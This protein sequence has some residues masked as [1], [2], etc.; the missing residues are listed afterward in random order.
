MTPLIS[1]VMTTYNR[2]AFLDCA[3]ASVLQQ[4]VS[5][6]ELLVWD[7]GSTDGSVE[8]AQAYAQQDKR[9][10][11]VAAAH[12]GRVKAL[13]AAIAQTQ[14]KYLGFV[15]SDDW[16]APTALEETVRVLE[17]QPAVGMVYTDYYETDA[18]GKVLQ[19]GQRCRIPYSPERL[20]VDFMTFHF[21]LLRRSPYD[22]VGGIKDSLDFVEDYDL[23]LRLS[24]V[25]QFERV[26]KPLYFYRIHAHNASRELQ[27]EQ[28][29][30]THWIL[31]QALRRRG[32]ADTHAID[33][34]LPA[35]RFT[36]R[37]KEAGVDS[38][39]VKPSCDFGSQYVQEAGEIQALGG[40]PP[41]PPEL[42][43]RRR[44]PNPLP[45]ELR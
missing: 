9:V 37:K 10:R 22:Q 34:D 13:T 27:V 20:L 19:Y 4:T 45:K 12:Q 6:F 15:D 7:D 40:N 17:A 42:R 35:G 5:N 32:M 2:E 23:C 36:L 21:R 43:G 33:L 44:P 16:L 1:L 26:R 25:T 29:L 38:S 18:Q 14:G 8:L 28:T 39:Q 31:E 11:V 24:E 3:I 30:R 41:K